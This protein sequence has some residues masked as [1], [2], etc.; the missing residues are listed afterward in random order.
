MKTQKNE[1]NTF[2]IL[3]NQLYMISRRISSY[4]ICNDKHECISI[5][6]FELNLTTL[7]TDKFQSTKEHDQAQNNIL[8]IHSRLSHSSYTKK[9]DMRTY[10]VDSVK[11]NMCY[12]HSFEFSKRLANLY[13]KYKKL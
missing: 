13:T 5:Y 4:K 1:E 2:C 12:I 8:E 3:L 10:I 6:S 11:Y 9:F 7:L